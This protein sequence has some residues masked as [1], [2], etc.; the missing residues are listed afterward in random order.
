MAY[1]FKMAPDVTDVRATGMVKEVE[2]DLNRIVKVI[3]L[4]KLFHTILNFNYRRTHVL[5]HISQ[6][7]RR[8]SG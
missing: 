6:L 7:V 4:F 2:D 8:L 1:G 5:C 3:K